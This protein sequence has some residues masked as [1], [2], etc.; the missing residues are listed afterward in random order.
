MS[1]VENTVQST[2]TKGLRRAGAEC[3]NAA[4][5]D[6]FADAGFAFDEHGGG[7]RRDEFQLRLKIGGSENGSRRAGRRA[8]VIPSFVVKS[9]AVLA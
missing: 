3:V 9:R 5:G 4:G 1:S 2:G 8:V 6:F 7:A